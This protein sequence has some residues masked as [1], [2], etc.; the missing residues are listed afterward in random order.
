L[1]RLREGA[2]EKVTLQER[3]KHHRCHA[4]LDPASSEREHWIAD[5]VRN[6]KHDVRND[7]HDVRDD[8]QNVRNDK[9]D[10]RN[11]KR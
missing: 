2:I 7:K 1:L 8:K 11:D 10:V 4:G 6:D 9:H 5:Q 3:R